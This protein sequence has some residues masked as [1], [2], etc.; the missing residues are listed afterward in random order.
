MDMRYLWRILLAAML[1]LLAAG[2]ALAGELPV[3]KVGHVGHDH[4]IALYVAADEG[5][6]LEKHY[7]VYLEK[8][9]DFEVYDLY[10]K[11]RAVA[12]VHFVRVGG[13]AKMPAALSAG[14]IEVGL[15]GLGPVAKFVDKGAGIKVLAPL[16][17]DGDFLVLTKRLKATNWK[18]FVAEVK[19]SERPVRIGYKAPMA[20]AYMILTRALDEEG[21]PYGLMPAERTGRL[22]KVV[23]VN[24][25]GM[26]NVPPSMEGGIIDGVVI[27]E[28]MASILEHKGFGRIVADL[29]ELPPKGKWEGHPCCIVAA[30]SKAISGKRAIVKSLLKLVA[31]GGDVM[32]L[33]HDRAFAAESR[34]TRTDPEVGKRSIPNVSYVNGPDEEWNKG[35]DTWIGLMN[36]SGHFKGRLKGMGVDDVREE[37]LD[38]SIIEEALGEIRLRSKQ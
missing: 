10:D 4:Q 13:G 24:L 37:I 14:Q 21:I 12:R 32:A 27:N 30:T 2:A 19:A 1:A 3:I 34:W 5:R 17:N 8:L 9:K 20:V 11:G 16:N 33:D 29:K 31:A 18:E 35:V 25:Q 22:N 26:K 28:P 23:T 36:E 15:G 7:G 6:A 38:L